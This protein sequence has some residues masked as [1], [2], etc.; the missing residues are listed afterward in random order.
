MYVQKMSKKPFKIH[1]KYVQ[2]TSKIHSKYAQNMTKIRPNYAN[3]STKI[4]PKHPKVCHLGPKVTF[5]FQKW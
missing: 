1:P 4:C 3:T 2:I 5:M